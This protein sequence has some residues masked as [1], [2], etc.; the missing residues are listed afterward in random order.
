VI[1]GEDDSVVAEKN[2]A[3]VLRQFLIF[4]GRVGA[5]G[6]PVGPDS[7]AATPL[8]NGRTITRDDYRVDGRV[9]ARRIRVSA[10]GHAWSGGDGA[11]AY[12]DPEAPDATELFGE[13][14]AAQLRRK[15]SR[16]R[17]GQ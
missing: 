3:E 5:D 16:R 4:N 9:V 15:M 6:A 2:A 1:H 7:T 14:F 11:F 12:N 10:L 8:P 17:I 13:F